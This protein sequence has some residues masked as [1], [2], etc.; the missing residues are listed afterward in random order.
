MLSRTLQYLTHSARRRWLVVNTASFG[1]AFLVLRAL[2]VNWPPQLINPL[3]DFLANYTRPTFSE[4]PTHL[5]IGTAFSVIYSVILGGIFGGI[6]G[7][8]VWL[9]NRGGFK[10][11]KR[12]LAGSGLGYAAGTLTLVLLSGL[13]QLPTPLQVFIND[14]SLLRMYLVITL[15]PAALPLAVLMGG[16]SGGVYGL[17]IGL[18]QAA[19]LHWRGRMLRRWLRATVL[20][21]AA[22]SGLAALLSSLLLMRL[23]EGDISQAYSPVN[24]L[25]IFLLSGLLIGFS[26]A[27][28]TARWAIR[29]RY[30]LRQRPVEDLAQPPGEFEVQQQ[31]VQPTGDG[32]G[33]TAEEDAPPYPAAEQTDPPRQS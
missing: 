24:T 17:W 32:S 10:L 19:S 4:S 16:L 21:L 22:G 30:G 20:S 9:L 33:S 13:L 8:G 6:T 15:E 27:R 11:P 2:A 28:L 23:S 3:G 26:Y 25:A 7:G 29:Y 5:L 1:L 12:W 31:T 14:L 18:G